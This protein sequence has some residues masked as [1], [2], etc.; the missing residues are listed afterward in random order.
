[1]RSPHFRS[2]G[3]HSLN[4]V[5]DH[6]IVANGLFRPLTHCQLLQAMLEQMTRLCE[7][8]PELEEGHPSNVYDKVMNH[9]AQALHKVLSARAE[10]MVTQVDR[11]AAYQDRK[12]VV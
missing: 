12:S 3:K 11:D 9:V 7:T 2:L 4:G 5:K 1:M 8:R 10:A 6:L